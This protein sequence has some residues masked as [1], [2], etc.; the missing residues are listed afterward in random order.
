MAVAS[1][2]LG[3]LAVVFSPVLVGAVLGLAS[4]CLG[5]V[6]VTRRRSSRAIAWWGVGLAFL[7]VTASVAAGAVY[8]KWYR[9]IA[10]VGRDGG[11]ETPSVERWKGVRAPQITLT[12]V[13]GERVDLHALKGRRVV[14]DFWAS[15]CN[16]CMREL[17]HFKRLAEAS[18]AD[19][20]IVGIS[21]EDAATVKRVAAEAGLGYPIAAAPSGLPKP[22]D[23]IEGLP[24]TFFIDRQG[25]IQ[26]V[27]VGYHDYEELREHALA[28]DF[29]GSAVDG[30]P[31]DVVSLPA[32]AQG[33]RGVPAWSRPLPGGVALGVGDWDGNGSAALLVAS[34]R[35]IHVLD[36]NGAPK[37]V[38][39]IPAPVSHLECSS[40]GGDGLRILGY[41]TWGREVSVFDRRGVRLWSYQAGKGVNGAHWGDLDGD[42]VPELIV[43]TNGAAGLHVVSRDGNVLWKASDISNVWS[44]SVLPATTRSKGFVF[45]TEASGSIHVY[46]AD[47]SLARTLQPMGRYYSE[48]ASADLDGQGTIQILAQGHGR[49]VALDPEGTLAWQSKAVAQAG[50]WQT[51]HLAVADLRGDGTREWVFLEAPTRLVLASSTGEKL[52]ELAVPEGSSFAIV[53]RHGGRGLLAVLDGQTVTAYAF[54]QGP[55]GAARMTLAA[56]TQDE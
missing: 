19:L 35:K 1:L 20:V 34:G 12:T 3:V 44:Q 29:A 54:E 36:P 9:M 18:P 46:A 50:A 42:G 43:G 55:P 53:P 5:L 15:W 14:L 8:Y 22:F 30:P 51:S 56:A 10:D 47:G 2:V 13:G 16:P 7:G 21:D 49:V 17:P 11:H 27:L 33:L 52:A 26:S 45:A 48:L 40:G 28:A 32:A 25:V 37:S 41:E 23:Q 38:L 39:T 4:L 24:T 31:P 6:H